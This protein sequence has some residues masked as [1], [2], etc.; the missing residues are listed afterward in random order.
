METAENFEKT[1]VVEEVVNENLFVE[2][3][4]KIPIWDYFAIDKSHYLSLS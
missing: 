3:M 1:A 4:N 2:F